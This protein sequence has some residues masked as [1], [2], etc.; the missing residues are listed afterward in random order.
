MRKSRRVLTGRSLLQ[1]K[2][3][4]TIRFKKGLFSN[5][6]DQRARLHV[7]FNLYHISPFLFVAMDAKEV[8]FKDTENPYERCEITRTNNNFGEPDRLKLNWDL[9][10]K[11]ANLWLQT[12]STPNLRCYL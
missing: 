2:P 9:S 6:D 1:I 10:L 5:S 12:V 4:G 11:P 8:L 3:K 7:R